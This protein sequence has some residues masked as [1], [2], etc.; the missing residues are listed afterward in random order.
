ML[1]GR[2][3][4][5]IVA[6][7]KHPMLTGS[8]LLVVEFEDGRPPLVATDTIGAGVGSIVLVAVGS[9]AARIAAPQVP[10]DAVIVGLL[11]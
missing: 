3:S 5:S 10:T 1:V 4:E 7:T 11:H 9:H 6:P 2:V 8:K